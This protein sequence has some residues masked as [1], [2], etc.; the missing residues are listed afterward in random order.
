LQLSASVV[1]ADIPF[2]GGVLHTLNSTL[3]A[4][5]NISATAFMNG[6]YRFLEAMEE[7]NMVSDLESIHDG[8][9]F[10]PTD[11]AWQRYKG[12]MS[13]MTPAE[14]ASILRYH[15]IEGTVLYHSDLSGDKQ[16]IKSKE[17]QS[18]TLEADTHGNVRV[19]GVLAIK[20]DLIWYGGV[21]YVIDEVLVP[22]K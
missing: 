14:I 18:L 22:G 8:T 21:A 4:P 13:G 10:V 9:L 5:H 11:A 20:E 16:E 7:S 17:G 2:D 3:V 12:T 15:A 6:L 19:N 1:Q